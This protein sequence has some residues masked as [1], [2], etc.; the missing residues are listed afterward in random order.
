VGNVGDAASELYAGGASPDDMI[1]S[2]E[3][4]SREAAVAAAATLYIWMITNQDS[5]IDKT[6]LNNV[7]RMSMLLDEMVPGSSVDG[8]AA[9]ELE[10]S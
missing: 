9:G 7:P 8:A 10:P 6:Y 3:P 1:G 2:D 5:R 4:V